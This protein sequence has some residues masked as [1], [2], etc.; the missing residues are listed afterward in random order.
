MNRLILLDSFKFAIPIIIIYFLVK[1]SRKNFKSLAEELIIILMLFYLTSFSYLLWFQPGPVYEHQPYN[2]EIFSTIDLY[3]NQLTSG[4]MPLKLI[5]INLMGNV[6]ITMPI[7]VWL[8]YKNVR[9]IKALIIA[10]FIP[11]LIELGQ[12]IFH[13]LNYATRVVD[14]DDWLLNAI[15]I[16]IGYWFTELLLKRTTKKIGH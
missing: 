6:I 12:Y 9:R 13:L 10:L 14:I 3:Y 11:V 4:F 2:F 7:G 15:G 16:L 8:S 5:V 1:L